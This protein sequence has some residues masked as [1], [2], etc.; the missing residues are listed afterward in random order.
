[1]SQ[2]TIFHFLK[3]KKKNLKLF[4]QIKTDTDNK[5]G[6]KAGRNPHCSNLN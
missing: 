2:F 5:G 4:K 6:I 3:K 1:M